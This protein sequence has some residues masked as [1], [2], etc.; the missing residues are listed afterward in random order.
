LVLALPVER[1]EVAHA[2]RRAPWALAIIVAMIVVMVS[3]VVSAVIAAL[4]AGM[5]LVAT[6][7]VT[8]PQAYRAVNWQSLVLIA[9]MLPMGTALSKT[10][11][12][13]VGVEKLILVLGDVGPLGLMAALYLL[14]AFLSQV[15][16][17]TATTVLIAPVAIGVATGLGVSPYPL[18]M[19]VA[20][21]ASAAYVTPMASPVNTLVLGPGGYRF[22]DYVRVGLPL[23]VLNMILTLIVVPLVF[24]F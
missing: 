7:C 15:I 1:E 6:G 14:T 24:P 16:S 8:M 11:A 5:A 4:A 9:G 21:A 17:N 19:A 10:G 20:L 22:A 2:Y 13:D 3:G 23:L 12:L 18:V